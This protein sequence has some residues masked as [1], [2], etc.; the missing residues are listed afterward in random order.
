VNPYISPFELDAMIA[1]GQAAERLYSLADE[2]ASAERALRAAVSA[3]WPRVAAALTEALPVA[4]ASLERGFAEQRAGLEALV[5][6]DL[7]AVAAEVTRIRAE[8]GDT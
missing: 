4:L 7:D 8:R 2:Q 5:R 3:G 1:R 6:G